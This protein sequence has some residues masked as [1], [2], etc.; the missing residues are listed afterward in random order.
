[1]TEITGDGGI[2]DSHVTETT[3]DGRIIIVLSCD[4]TAAK[5]KA[6]NYTVTDCW[7]ASPS[8]CRPLSSFFKNGMTCS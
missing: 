2:V 5:G 4:Y 1:M 8:L 6:Y 3:G 7:Y